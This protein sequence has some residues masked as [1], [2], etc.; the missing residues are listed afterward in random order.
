[1][2]TNVDVDA[3]V[4]TINPPEGLLEATTTAPKV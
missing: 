4:M 3:K 1:M 2:V